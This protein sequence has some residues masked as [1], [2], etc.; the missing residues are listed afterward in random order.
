MYK[1]EQTVCLYIG[2]STLF[3]KVKVIKVFQIGLFLFDF[4]QETQN[5]EMSTSK[6]CLTKYWFV[7]FTESKLNRIRR[8]VSASKAF[9][10]YL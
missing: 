9:H 2:S 3:Y 6:H 5:T 8:N 7:R 10:L 1:A 4:Y